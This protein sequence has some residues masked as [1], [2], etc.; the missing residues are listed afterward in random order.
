MRDGKRCIPATNRLLPKQRR[1]GLRP[2]CSDALLS[3]DPVAQG[4]TKAIP[5]S[6]AGMVGLCG[7]PFLRGATGFE[8]LVIRQRLAPREMREHTAAEFVLQTKEFPHYGEHQNE[9]D[10]RIKE[11]RN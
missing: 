4:T 3:I 11:D 8:R 10:H 1:P 7:R 6:T 5:V 2:V 9:I